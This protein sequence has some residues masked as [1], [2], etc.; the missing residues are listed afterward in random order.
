MACA[1]SST[2]ALISITLIFSPLSVRVLTA[3]FSTEEGWTRHV[4]SYMLV[5]SGSSMLMKGDAIDRERDVSSEEVHD[6]KL[7][8][9][10]TYKPPIL[11]KTIQNISPR[12]TSRS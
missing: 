12:F 11:K 3:G 4:I 5:S 8:S 2:A 10:T 1:S 6:K 7:Q 9:L